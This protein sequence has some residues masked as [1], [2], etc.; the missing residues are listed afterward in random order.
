M[1]EM[2]SRAQL[3]AEWGVSLSTVKRL[4]ARADF[5]TAVRLGG[6]VRWVADEVDKW[7]EAQRGGRPSRYVTQYRVARDAPPVILVPA[8]GRVA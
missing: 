3:A 5:P 1:A 6:S 2:K 4:T 8:G 7:A